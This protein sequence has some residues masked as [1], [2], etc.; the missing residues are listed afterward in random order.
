MP[1]VIECKSLTS[2]SSQTSHLSLLPGWAPCPCY[3][4]FVVPGRLG[5]IPGVLPVVRPAPTPAHACK[6]TRTHTHTRH[7]YF[8]LSPALLPGSLA[9]PLEEAKEG[10]GRWQVCLREQCPQAYDNMKVETF[11]LTKDT[12]VGFQ[13]LA[14]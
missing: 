9:H 11:V 8:Y 12:S 1:S 10:E 4:I 5:L 14:L 6:S 3:S 2:N 13:V 7:G